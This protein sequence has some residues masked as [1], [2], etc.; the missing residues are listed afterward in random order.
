MRAR[1]AGRDAGP[2]TRP[3]SA[4]GSRTKGPSS[5]PMRLFPPA[6]PRRRLPGRPAAPA[7]EPNS[8][9]GARAG[10][11][12]PDRRRQPV[13]QPPPRPEFSLSAGLWVG[14]LQDPGAGSL[15]GRRVYLARCRRRCRRGLYARQDAGW[16]VC[17][18]CRTG[19]MTVVPLGLPT[20]VGYMRQSP[21]G[22]SSDGF[23]DHIALHGCD[24]DARIAD[25]ARRRADPVLRSQQDDSAATTP[26]TCMG[27]FVTQGSIGSFDQSCS[28]AT[29]STS[30]PISRS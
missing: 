4:A 19:G 29:S 21:K 10:E 16:R 7:P 24:G 22:D 3:P 11:P 12:E 20:E 6:P 28:A 13:R 26:R 27:Y 30:K 2:P 23:T 8:A 25:R 15:L 1:R 18:G 14:A 5:P 17:P 9:S